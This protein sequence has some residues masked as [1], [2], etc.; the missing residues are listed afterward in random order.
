[1]LK[2]RPHVTTPYCTIL[3][4]TS[5]SRFDTRTLSTQRQQQYVRE[6]GCARSVMCLLFA[7]VLWDFSNFLPLTRSL[8]PEKTQK[9]TAYRR[10]TTLRAQPFS[11]MYC[12]LRCVR[13]VRVSNLETIFDHFSWNEIQNIFQIGS[14]W[15]R[16]YRNR[17]NWFGLNLYPINSASIQG[18]SPNKSEPSF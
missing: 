17:S 3:A 12:C 9:T 18:I 2:K 10:H 13:N 16:M 1:M 4:Q 8:Q 14:E 11:R 5:V 7:V 6:N 15:L